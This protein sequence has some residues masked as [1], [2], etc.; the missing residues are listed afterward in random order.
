MLFA[1]VPVI[2]PESQEPQDAF[3]G[4]E[5]NDGGRDDLDAGASDRDIAVPTEADVQR[6]FDHS[7]VSCHSYGNNPLILES[8]TRQIVNAETHGKDNCF[9]DPV[10]LVKP[11]NRLESY[12]YQKIARL[13]TCGESMPPYRQDTI[14]LRPEQVELVGAWIDALT[15]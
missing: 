12:L 10:V 5:K 6:I 7:C 4:V 2:D 3:V 11:G 15:P 14:P 1:C 9:V 13:Q 8:S